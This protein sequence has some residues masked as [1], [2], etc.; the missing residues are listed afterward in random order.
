MGIE[1]NHKQEGLL[2]TFDAPFNQTLVSQTL[3][4]SHKQATPKMTIDPPF[5][6]AAL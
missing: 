4:T 2:G 1:Q 6:T 3:S 5:N